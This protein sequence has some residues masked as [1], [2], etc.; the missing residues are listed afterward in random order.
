MKLGTRL[1]LGFAGILSLLVGLA[2]V[3][4]AKVDRISADLQT[5]NT[6]N[7]VKQRYAINFRGS[8]HDRAILMR[9]VI[10]LNDKSDLQAT[11]DGIQQR[12]TAYASSAVA[13]DK[14]MAADVG[15]TQDERDILA[16]IKQTE[17]RTM[18]L[19]AEV[20]RLQLAGQQGPALDLLRS[21]ARPAFVE[22]LARINKFIDLEEQ[23]NQVVGRTVQD[24]ANGFGIFMLLLCGGALSAGLVIAGWTFLSIR[25]LRHLAETVRRLAANDLTAEV[26]G[27]ERRDEIGDIAGAVLVFRESAI[28]KTAADADKAAAEA[29]LEM[30]VETLGTALSQLSKRDLTYRITAGFSGGCAVLKDNYN[31]ALES[32]RSTVMQVT[33]SAQTIST[34]TNEMAQASEDLAKRTE[35]NAASLEE[36]SA[37]LTQMETRLKATANASQSTVARADQAM[38]TVGSGRSTAEFAMQAMGRVSG[39]AKGIDDVIEGLDKIAFQTR[40]L[41]MNAAVE[42][43]RAGDAGRGFAVVADLVSALAMRAEEEAKRARDQLSVTQNEIVTAVDAVGKV[44]SALSAISDDVAEVN[45]LLA[46]M[47]SDNVD[48]STTIT[49]ITAAVSTM[50]R[51]TQQ[52]AAM[53]EHT[54]AAARNLT[55]EV[56]TL[57]DATA[58]FSSERRVRAIPVAVDRRRS[59]DRA[60]APPPAPASRLP[61]ASQRPAA[62][63][64]VVAADQANGFAG[65]MSTDAWSDF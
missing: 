62:R 12:V 4:S 27:A 5:I 42:A 55:Q 16:S 2:A 56:R 47:A 58:Q 25:P 31:D 29:T 43:G 15:V 18:P 40:V 48:Q 30:V 17:A 9:D 10:L 34:G 39:S 11:F 64:K 60:L 38:A 8:A 44:D 41:A 19:M 35:S 6:V 22:W 57:V 49:E 61:A 26:A 24:A 13:L 65:H 21:D 28:A 36:T 50:D 63:L 52:N 23:K 33:N 7:S 54:S 3:S 20:I 32:M 46:G 45:R 1:L 53:V 14:M 37:A 51:S 59:A